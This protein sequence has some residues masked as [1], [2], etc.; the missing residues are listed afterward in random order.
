MVCCRL[1]NSTVI[2]AFF[3]REMNNLNQREDC[4][5]DTMT[6]VPENPTDPVA[7]SMSNCVNTESPQRTELAQIHPAPD[8]PVWLLVSKDVAKIVPNSE[9]L[10]STMVSMNST[11]AKTNVTESHINPSEAAEYPSENAQRPDS[12]TTVVLPVTT[13]HILDKNKLDK[14]S[15]A[16]T[17]GSPNLAEVVI[18]HTERPSHR[19]VPNDEIEPS[20]TSE[21]NR[22][23]D[24]SQ[25]P[26]SSGPS[27]VQLVLEQPS[28]IQSN[29]V[30][31]IAC[32]QEILENTRQTVL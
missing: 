9:I 23:Q 26:S 8:E 3:F 16:D 10:S 7:K 31:T 6:N 11:Q 30:E 12:K 20:R 21:P 24:G 17:L 5:R 25:R 29:C 15:A 22:L 1:G 19:N 14:N 4:E 27:C 2:Q 28:S 13:A 18:E 32:S